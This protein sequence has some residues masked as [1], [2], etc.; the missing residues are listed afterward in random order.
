M[1]AYAVL[2]DKKLLSSIEDFASE[3]NMQ[4]VVNAL[5]DCNV[6]QLVDSMNL[7][8]LPV[9]SKLHLIFEKGNKT[10]IIAI[11]DYFTQELFSPLHD[12]L[13]NILRS[14]PMDC[15]FDQDKGFLTSL[16]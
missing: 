16:S 14:I 10:R 6:S 13:A 3:T 7:N 9:H 12:T 4:F 1:D 5:K 15:T 11:V 8:K 2:Q